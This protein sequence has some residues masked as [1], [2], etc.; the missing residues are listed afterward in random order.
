MIEGDSDGIGSFG[1]GCR[2]ENR[3][4]KERCENPTRYNHPGDDFHNTPPSRFEN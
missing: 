4:K 2:Y 1:I 3:Q